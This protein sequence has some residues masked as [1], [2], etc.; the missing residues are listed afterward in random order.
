MLLHTLVLWDSQYKSREIEAFGLLLDEGVA[1]L[2]KN[3][4]IFV[5]LLLFYWSLGYYYPSVTEC[6]PQKM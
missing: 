5:S 1:V 4:C 2:H 6:T 3:D